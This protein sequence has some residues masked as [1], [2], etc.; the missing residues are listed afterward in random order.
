MYAPSIAEGDPVSM[1][2]GNMSVED[3]AGYKT[4]GLDF[5]VECEKVRCAVVR[6]FDFMVLGSR[7]EKSSSLVQVQP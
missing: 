4:K 5:G 2:R 6:L 7:I 1:T 3:L